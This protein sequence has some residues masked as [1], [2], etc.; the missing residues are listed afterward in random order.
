VP[1]RDPAYVE[2]TARHILREAQFRPK[3]QNLLQRAWHWILD[4][5][6]SLFG[7]SLGGPH[8]PPQVV[9]VFI[10]AGLAVV[11]AVI[12]RR[13]GFGWGRR[14]AK[15]R[16]KAVLTSADDVGVAAS[17]WLDRAFAA[18]QAGDWRE[19]V[20]CRYRALI[21]VAAAAGALREAVGRT[22]GEYLADMERDRPAA[23]A[24]FAVATTIFEG[25]WY[26]RR[27]AGPAQRDAMIAAAEGLVET[28]DRVP[29]ESVPAGSGS[30]G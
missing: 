13:G 23:A 9:V 11:I 30:I 12:A 10:V 14:P 7:G 19:G 17:A 4:Q 29:A 25:V 15:V 18:E 3:G 28:V 1:P 21:A 22:A 6:N 24:S 5:L 2:S 16:A 27:P 8:L 20:R 26:G